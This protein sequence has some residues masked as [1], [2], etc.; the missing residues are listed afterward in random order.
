ENAGN[1]SF[2][3][4]FLRAMVRTLN[5]PVFAVSYR[6]Y[7][8]SSGSPSERGLKLDCEA[9]LA[10]LLSRTD[11]NTSSVFV[12]G[13]SLGGAVATHL[14]A[15]HQDK[16]KGLIIEN[17]FT[18]VENM[19]G[20]LLPP[21][22]PLIGCGK[23]LNFLVK[24]KWSNLK[25]LPKITKVPLLMLVSGKDEMVPPRQMWQLHAAQRAPAC[26]IV[27]LP[28][29]HHMDAYDVEPATYWGTLSDF[30]TKNS[31]GTAGR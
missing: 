12:F 11:V 2:R 30:V 6:G 21:L 10:H 18:S 26:T 15:A 14:T 1:M 22:G 31:Q 19:V 7:G 23:P 17:T 28:E 3:L 20:Q 29:A 16:I 13:R 27:E 24:D 4:P 9:G 25:T 8:K 5:C